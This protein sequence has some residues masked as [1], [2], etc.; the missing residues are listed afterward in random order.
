MESFS[1]VY[2][3]YLGQDRIDQPLFKDRDH[4]NGDQ[5]RECIREL[6]TCWEAVANFESSHLRLIKGRGLH[7]AA[8]AVCTESLPEIIKKKL[9]KLGLRMVGIL[10]YEHSIV[11]R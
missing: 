2:G 10:K 3:I 11:E 4:R 8:G 6:Y 1:S 9:R 7:S 5:E